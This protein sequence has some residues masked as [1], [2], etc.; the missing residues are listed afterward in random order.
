MAGSTCTSKEQVRSSATESLR[1]HI[2]TKT[3][4]LFVSNAGGLEI[5]NDFDLTLDIHVA[6]AVLTVL[7][8]VS[9]EAFVRFPLRDMLNLNCWLA[10]IPPPPLDNHGVRIEGAPAN[11]AL[12][13]LDMTAKELGLQLYCH[14]CTSKALLELS[15]LLASPE[16][17]E[18]MT[19]VV[20]NVFQS[21]TRNLKGGFVQDQINRLLVEAP[22]QCGHT[23]EFDPKA[24]P[25]TYEMFETS[26][27]SSTSSYITMLV[28]ILI[29]ILL[30]IAMAFCVKRSMLQR[31]KKWMLG[32]P[33]ER[34]FLIHQ[35][36][37]RSDHRE[38]ELNELTS[39][40]YKSQDIPLFVRQLIPIVVVANIGF[41]LSGHLNKGGRVLI[42][43][44]FA[45]ESFQIDDFYTF[46]IGQ[47]ALDMWHNGGKELAVLILLFSGVWPYTKQLITLALWFLPPSVVS[48]TRRGQFLNWLDILAKWSMID[49]MVMLITIV[50]FR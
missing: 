9:E 29:P 12:T 28:V 25:V 34:V 6:T 22:N 11:A 18:D 26:N 3:E 39:S 42:D 38:A 36:Q 30:M 50:G 5:I 24:T 47:S 31:H 20:N 14:N 19:K 33:S 13:D 37:E 45:G 46:S 43:L 23:D 48:C 2:I 7:L 35:K 17:S 8:K 16:S 40:M 44:A 21:I 15:D 27:A 32:L 49:I 4:L 1:A 10:M 41:F